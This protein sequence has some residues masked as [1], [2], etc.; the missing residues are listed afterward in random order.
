VEVAIG[1]GLIVVLDEIAVVECVGP[2]VAV[3][4]GVAGIADPV[5]IGVELITVG[6]QPTVVRA[7]NDQ[8]AVRVVTRVARAVDV[9]LP[10]VP[11][12]GTVVGVVEHAVVVGVGIAGVALAHTIGV[13]LI[14]VRDQR[15]V[16]PVV[17]DEVAIVV[18]F[19]FVVEPVTVGV[20]CANAD[21]GEGRDDLALLARAEAVQVASGRAKPQ[22]RSVNCDRRRSS[23]L[24]ARYQISATPARPMPSTVKPLC[25]PPSL[26]RYAALLGMPLLVCT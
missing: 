24:R 15:A 6:G 5:A 19:F 2:N 23:R 9:A 25:V 26:T 21:R 11:S 8:V 20:G 14:G 22:R 13:G 17:G 10:G 7:V 16:V 1:V 18:V 12:E 3:V 4:V